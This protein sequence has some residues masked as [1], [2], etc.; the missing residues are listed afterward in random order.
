MSRIDRGLARMSTPSAGQ[1]KSRR[2]MS[3]QQALEWAFR[4]EKAQLELP[5]RRTPSTGT[6]AARPS[7][8]NMS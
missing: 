2:A 4:I 7:A 1:G 8:S 5:E 3:V 6:V